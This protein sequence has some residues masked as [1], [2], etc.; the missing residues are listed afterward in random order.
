MHEVSH[1]ASLNS[2]IKY[3][4]FPSIEVQE[5]EMN[6]PALKSLNQEFKQFVSKFKTRVIS[7]GVARTPIISV[8]AC[9]AHTLIGPV[10]LLYT[11]YLDAGPP[12]ALVC[13][14]PLR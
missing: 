1:K 8:Y 14:S 9:T 2:I 4:F 3:F 5:L 13:V 6:N 11:L 12:L 7:F 10:V